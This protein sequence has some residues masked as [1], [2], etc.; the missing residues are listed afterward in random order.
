MVETRWGGCVWIQGVLER[1]S[2]EDGVGVI[3]R[4]DSPLFPE[5]F[6][7]IVSL[8]YN[9]RPYGWAYIQ[10]WVVRMSGCGEILEDY[11]MYYTTMWSFIIVGPDRKDKLL[12]SVIEARKTG[13]GHCRG[14]DLMPNRI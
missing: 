8:E 12:T 13:Q 11:Y 3:F 6:P 9:E 14:G 1:F 10:Y 4:D 5:C 2:N 7:G